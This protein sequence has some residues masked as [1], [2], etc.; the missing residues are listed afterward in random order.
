MGRL[1]RLS[2]NYPTYTNLSTGGAMDELDTFFINLGRFAYNTFAEER[3]DLSHRPASIPTWN[4][5]KP[6]VQEAWIATAKALHEQALELA[7]M[8]DSLK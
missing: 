5:L 4:K 2:G 3:T 7:L 6:D 8:K 1:G